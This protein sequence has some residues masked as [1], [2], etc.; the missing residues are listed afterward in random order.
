MLLLTTSHL[1]QNILIVSGHRVIRVDTAIRPLISLQFVLSVPVPL[2]LLQKCGT[3]QWHNG[4]DV[5][6][7]R[8]S[9]R[10]SSKTQSV[11]QRGRSVTRSGA[12]SRLTTQPTPGRWDPPASSPSTDEILE[13]ARSHQQ[14][15]LETFVRGDSPEPED[16]DEYRLLDP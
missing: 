1:T 10:I 2:C 14:R 13:Q 11:E 9:V 15:N 16:L 5:T 12:N 7:L 6:R 3:R 4:S 8:R